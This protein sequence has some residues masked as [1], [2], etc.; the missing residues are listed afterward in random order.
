MKNI[1]VLLL[2]LLLFSTACSS[3]NNPIETETSTQASVETS[4]NAVTDGNTPA[5]EETPPLDDGFDAVRRSDERW[6]SH[7]LDAY[8]SGKEVPDLSEFFADPANMVY[9]TLYTD[10]FLY[11]EAKSIPVAEAFFCFVVETYGKDALLDTDRRI[12]YKSAYLASLGVESGYL[13]DPRVEAML[14][15]M[16]A[17]SDKDRAYILTVDNTT[18]TLNDFSQ[19]SISQYHALFYNNTKALADMLTFIRENLPGAG[20][21]TDRHFRYDMTFDGTGISFTLSDGRMSINDMHSMLHESLHA[22]GL[23]ADTDEF[24]WLTEGLCNYMGKLMGFNPQLASSSAQVLTMAG[25]GYFDERIESGDVAAVYNKR[26]YEAYTAA[27]GSLSSAA[28]FDLILYHDLGAVLERAVLGE[29]VQTIADA[30]ETLNNRP[31]T[32]PG[33]E[34]TYAETTSMVN[35]LVETYGLETVMKAA[36]N[37]D[38]EGVLG[39]SYDE[40]KVLWQATLPPV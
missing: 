17:S 19:G 33:T 34:L 18:Y 25:A 40:L 3:A 31:Y 10:M 37:E 23:R 36:Q 6:L 24:I 26:L 7:G 20:L 16:T 12:E 38:V 15:R 2:A 21:N 4:P 5:P 14:S 30:Y 11:D 29:T 22:M 35:Y 32:A 39:K 1:S 27:G 13:Q 9:L 8:L 28:E